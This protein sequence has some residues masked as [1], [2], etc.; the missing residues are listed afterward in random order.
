MPAK[1][2][3]QSTFL[4][5]VLPPSRASSL[6]QGST[7]NTTLVSTRENRGSGLA[8]D[9]AIA[10]N[11][12]AECAAAFAGKPAPTRDRCRPPIACSPKI[13]CGSE[14]AR[15]SG[16][17]VSICVECAAAFAS[18]LAPT[19][20]VVAT[21][22]ANTY[23]IQSVHSGHFFRRLPFALRHQLAGQRDQALAVV[24][25]IVERVEA[26]DQEGGD[27]QVVIVEQG[28]G[29]LFRGAHQ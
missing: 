1:A 7:V 22:L 20:A 10:V 12:S 27:A 13:P 24:D 29:H 15:E 25:G 9:G 23:V 26:A 8:R 5:N 28:F 18:K 2:V 6:P 21:I 17:S 3:C 11:I 14:L 16:G 4:L 19:G